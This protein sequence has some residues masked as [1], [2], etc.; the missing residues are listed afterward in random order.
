MRRFPIYSQRNFLVDA[1]KALRSADPASETTGTNLIEDCLTSLVLEEMCHI[2]EV[3]GRA[4]YR[5][6]GSL[7]TQTFEALERQ[8]YST[9]SEGWNRYWMSISETLKQS[10]QRLEELQARLIIDRQEGKPVRQRF[11]EGEE[12][13]EVPFEILHVPE[14]DSLIAVPVKNRCYIA[15]DRIQDHEHWVVSGEYFPFEIQVRDLTF[16]VSSAGE[17]ILQVKNFPESLIRE[18]V[19]TLRNVAQTLY[20]DGKP[21][22]RATVG[23]ADDSNLFR[24]EGEGG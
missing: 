1:I 10:A 16:V 19:G 15:L 6:P 20:T 17:I 2:V 5:H 8:L 22:F 7:L 3:Q 18:V 9:G 21:H 23:E 11:E 12:G 4:G 14:I 24:L 13:V